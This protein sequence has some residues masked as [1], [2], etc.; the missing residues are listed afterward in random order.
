MATI[1]VKNIPDDLYRRLKAAAES[2]RR[3]INGEII[4]GIER[5]LRSRGV[6]ADQLLARVGR[7]R[8]TYGGRTISIEELENARR[9][10]RP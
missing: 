2:N 1:T 9:E 4:G 7:L 6:A 8:E 5:S 10:G 3:G